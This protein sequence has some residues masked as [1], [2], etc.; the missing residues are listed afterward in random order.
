M[1]TS[2]H[3]ISRIEEDTAMNRIPVS[4]S[5]PSRPSQATRP[6]SRLLLLLCCLS[7]AACSG[8]GDSGSAPSAAD[9]AEQK[10]RKATQ[11]LVST[12]MGEVQK[13][14][15]EH[16]LA[17]T[18]THCSSRAQELSTL[19][20]AEEGV[21]I[22]RVTEKTRNPVDAPDA[23]ERRVLSH[24]ADLAREGVITPE[25]AH[26]EVVKKDGR[27]VLRFLKPVTVM[28]NCL[29]CHGTPEQIP[30]DVRQALRTQYPNDLATGYAVGDLRGA[31]SVIVPLGE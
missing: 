3:S 29:G 2:H 21:E 28:K 1:D 19:V 5:A 17:G 16:G 27:E 25:T 31:V 22:R 18:V 12:L 4:L 24:F 20:G 10:A 23:F 9:A 26:V 14:I 13:H 6:A 8:A 15:Q 30:D 7:L 11:R